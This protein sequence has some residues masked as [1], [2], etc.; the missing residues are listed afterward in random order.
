EY[1]RA[2]SANFRDHLKKYRRRL[3]KAGSVTIA[4]LEAHDDCDAWMAEVL[5]VNEASWT[6]Q[7]G[8][9]LFRQPRLRAFLVE[10]ATELAR[11]GWLDLHVLRIDDRAVAYELCFDFGGRVFS[12]NSSYDGTQA[13]HSPGT[14]VTAAVIEA[15]SARG[16]TEDDMLRGDEEY[17][18]RWSDTQRAEVEVLVPA[19]RWRSRC[20]ARLGLSARARL[21]SIPWLDDLDDRFSGVLSRLR[22]RTPSP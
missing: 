14:V 9:N 10:L 22:Y 21:K 3:N 13:R 7:R 5:A 16:R 2:R 1:L 6:A 15:A 11:R 17:K 8:T 4:R 20:Y 18:R 19:P 12:Y